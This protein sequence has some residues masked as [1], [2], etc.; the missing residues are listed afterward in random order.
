MTVELILLL[1]LSVFLVLGTMVKDF[2]G[3][4]FFPKSA[5]R[6]AARLERNISTGEGFVDSNGVAYRWENPKDAN[7]GVDLGKLK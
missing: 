2:G 1:C 5:P 6:L 7:V 4:G 3:K